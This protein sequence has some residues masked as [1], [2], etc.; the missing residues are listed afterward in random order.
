MFEYNEYAG[1]DGEP[2]CRACNGTGDIW[3][4]GRFLRVCNCTIQEEIQDENLNPNFLE[5]R[6]DSE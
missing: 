6:V 4:M 1:Y 3:A 5:D 2:V